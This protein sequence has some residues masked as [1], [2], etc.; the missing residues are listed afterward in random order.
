M[1][2]P[3]S[4]KSLS[5]WTKWIF[6]IE[7]SLMNHLLLTLFD[8]PIRSQIIRNTISFWSFLL[9]HLS[10][11]WSSFHFSF[12]LVS[13][14]E[15]EMRS[16]FVLAAILAVAFASCPVSNDFFDPTHI[17]I[18]LVSWYLETIFLSPMCSVGFIE[19][20]LAGNYLFRTG[21]PKYENGVC[22]SSANQ[23]FIFSTT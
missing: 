14:A 16:V 1:T 18:S 8:Q 21:M 9:F 23:L 17:R 11:L 12:L 3:S 22:F 20:S 10:L 6:K 4:L 7:K 15:L 5:F 2:S 19:K 13:F